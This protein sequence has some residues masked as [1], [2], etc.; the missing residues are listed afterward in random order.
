MIRRPPRSTLFPYTTL[1]R[2]QVCE[3]I[4]VEENSIPRTKNPSWRR[5]PSETNS[6]ADVVRVLIESRRQGLGVVTHAEINRQLAG[7]GP[8]VRNESAEPRHRKSQVRIPERLPKLPGI[9]RAQLTEG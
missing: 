7:D 4:P 9:P 6:R 1:F 3:N 5:T 8:M 2:S